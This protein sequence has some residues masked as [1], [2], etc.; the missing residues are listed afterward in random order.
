[1][2]VLQLIDSLR[3]GGA[4]RMAV[5]YANLL[6][7]KE[8]GSYICCTRGEGELKDQLSPEIGYLFLNKRSTLDIKAV[9]KLR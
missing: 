2:R 4:E 6:H 9:T 1:M 8:Q 5:S 3:P 7:K